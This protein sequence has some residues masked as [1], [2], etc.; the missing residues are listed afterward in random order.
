MRI[1]RDAVYFGQHEMPGVIAQ[2][3]ITLKPGGKDDMNRLT[4]EFLVGEVIADDPMV[5][6]TD[7]GTQ[8]Q[9]S[10]KI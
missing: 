5:T 1:T 8:V 10:S 4:I 3:G 9:Y 2:D 7:T 6:S